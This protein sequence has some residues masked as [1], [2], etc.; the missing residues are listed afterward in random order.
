MA[1]RGISREIERDVKEIKGGVHVLEQK[2][3]GN[4]YYPYNAD[5]SDQ[6][7]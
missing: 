4:F 1:C 5:F 3:R 2:A 7:R 6:K